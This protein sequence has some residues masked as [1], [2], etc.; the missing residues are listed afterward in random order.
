MN[1]YEKETKRKNTDFEHELIDDEMEPNVN[2]HVD[3]GHENQA[4]FT[5]VS[6]VSMKEFL[7]MY[8]YIMML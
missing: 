7:K 5:M 8:I 2:S 4:N 3:F 1:K 6:E